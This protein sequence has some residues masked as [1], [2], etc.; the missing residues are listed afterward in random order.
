MRP[1]GT[2]PG[3]GGVG[4]GPW[5]DRP[6]ADPRTGGS[7]TLGP[8]DVLLRSSFRLALGATD[9]TR[10]DAMRLTA[11]GRVAGTQFNGRDGDLSLNGK[12]LTGTVGVDGARDRWLAGVAVSHSL[13]GGSFRMTGDGDDDLDSSTLTSIHPYLRYALNERVDVWGVLGYGWGD[14]TLEPGTG[15]ALETDTKLMMGSFGGRG[16]LVLARENAGFEVAARTDAM[17]TRMRSG[18]VA[19]LTS[20]DAEVHRLRLILESSQAI[21]GLDGDS[22]TPSLALGLLRDWG[23][24]EIG[25]GLELAGRVRYADPARGRALQKSGRPS[26]IPAKAGIQG[27]WGGVAQAPDP[28]TPPG[29]PLARE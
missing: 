13:G 9:D 18:A 14:M 15:G 20:T 5:T 12:V 16:L 24:A 28:S 25:L 6:G 10:P 1:G 8:R 7:R 11:W 26:V 2:R 29:F 4:F 3:S 22:V 23:D 19:G 21:M 27:W 17:L